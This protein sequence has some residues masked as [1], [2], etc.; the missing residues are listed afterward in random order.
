MIRKHLN[1][2]R[3]VRGVK[4]RGSSD[5]ARSEADERYLAARNRQITAKARLA[6]LELRAKLRE[7]IPV[8]QVEADLSFLLGAIRQKVLAIHRVWPRRLVGQDEA[9][10]AATLC[11]LEESL[12]AELKDIGRCG[13]ADFLEEEGTGS[14]ED[15]EMA[16]VRQKSKAKKKAGVT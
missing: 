11:L 2:V 10:M 16:P 12:L 8:R 5:G 4:P 14:V 6:E 7:W 9:T 1:K 13:R 3:G 15:D